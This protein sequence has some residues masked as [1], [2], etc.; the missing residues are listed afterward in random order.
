[1]KCLC[2]TEGPINNATLVLCEMHSRE[3][4]RRL[5][6]MR[7]DDD[8]AI[9]NAALDAVEKDLV[10]THCNLNP[11]DEWICSRLGLLRKK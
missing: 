11:I 9:W 10:N 2:T 8:S 3:F 6:D 1:M 4:H 5:E 7:G